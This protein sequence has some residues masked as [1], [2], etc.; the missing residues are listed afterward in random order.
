M[1]IFARVLRRAGVDLQWG[2]RKRPI[3]NALVAISS[4]PL[5][6]GQGYSKSLRLKYSADVA[7]T[8]CAHIKAGG[9]FERTRQTTVGA[10]LIDT[11]ASVA[12]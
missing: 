7:Y 2:G 1:L 12:M 11:R 5:K 6:I 8:C 9:S 4:G 10:I 3:F